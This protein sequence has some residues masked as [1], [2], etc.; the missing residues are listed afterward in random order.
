M[1]SDAR[2][3]RGQMYSEALNLLTSAG[4]FHIKLGLERI[5]AVMELLGNPQDELKCIHVAGTNGKGSVCAILAS[6][7]QQAG[8][9]VG[10]YTS[11]HIYEYTERIKILDLCHPEL[12]SGSGNRQNPTMA[13]SRVKPG[14]TYQDI[15]KEDFARLV[16]KVCDN[17]I[18]LTEFEILT[19]VMFKYFADNKVDVVVL[20]TGLGGRHD[21]TNVIKSNLCAVITHVDFDH[22]ERLGSTL[23][24]ITAEKEGIIKPGCPV[25]K[26]NN[27]PNPP[28]KGGHLKGLFQRENTALALEVIKLLY[29]DLPQEV[30]DE[31]LK[32]VR[33][34]ARFQA[35]NDNLIVDA[36]HNPNGIAAL[37]ESL[38]F[39]YPE[40]PRR[41]VFG[42]LRNK[43]YKE[44]VK[45]LFRPQD[46]IYFYQFNNP[47]A[48]TFEELQAVCEFPA[49]KLSTRRL[50][51]RNPQPST[52]L[53]IVCGSIYMI[54]EIIPRKLLLA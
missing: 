1:N 23:E 48:C 11:P 12:D 34:P 18:P 16:F 13:R 9:K 35:V 24:E 51:R 36:A 45:T 20:E 19:A 26:F 46:E 52:S 50:D 31:G 22:T 47:N 43:N 33:H 17:D 5:S 29:P 44:M 41:F 54:S 53:T 15:N 39:Y 49:K 2:A 30:I 25:I 7:L 42:C 21:A 8:L 14:M 10:L 4:R 37:R 40:Q 32:N 38:D 6:I 28:Y 3:K 27:P